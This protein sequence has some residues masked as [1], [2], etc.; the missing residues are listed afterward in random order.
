[1][2]AIQ[3][4]A[5]VIEDSLSCTWHTIQGCSEVTEPA[6]GCKPGDRLADLLFGFLNIT[7][8]RDI[9]DQLSEAGITYTIP[10]LPDDVAGQVMRGLAAGD[11]RLTFA[12]FRLDIIPLTQLKSDTRSW[13]GEGPDAK[14]LWDAALADDRARAWRTTTYLAT[15]LCTP[16]DAEGRPVGQEASTRLSGH[17]GLRSGRRRR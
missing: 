2:N 5:A 4:L 15:A 12:R 9:D 7:V 3:H 6:T 1:M 17:R 11:E 10:R 16:A 8:L 14:A 13:T